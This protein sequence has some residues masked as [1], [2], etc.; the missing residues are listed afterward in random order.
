[1][2]KC[3]NCEHYPWKPDAD[4]GMM[5]PMQCHSKLDARKWTTDSANSEHSCLFYKG[6]VDGLPSE[7]FVGGEGVGKPFVATEASYPELTEKAKE[8]GIP[9]VGVKKEVL[10]SEI[11][12]L[13]SKGGE[14]NDSDS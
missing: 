8:L 3:I 4:P 5:P 1:M 2:A 11:E 13:L 9:F 12:A 10:V 7:P 6:P 14:P